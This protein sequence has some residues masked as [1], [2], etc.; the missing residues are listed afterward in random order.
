MAGE[1]YGKLCIGKYNNRQNT[2]GAPVLCATVPCSVYKLES[3]CVTFIECLLGNRGMI[4]LLAYIQMY[5]IL[6]DILI[7]TGLIVKKCHHFP[8]NQCLGV[9][10]GGGERDSKIL[11][12]S[13]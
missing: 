7:M 4:G 6:N 2:D 3:Y 9:V 8:N 5:W 12:T 10:G 13:P 11:S 1:S